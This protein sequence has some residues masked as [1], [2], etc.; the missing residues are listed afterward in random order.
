MGSCLCD[1]SWCVGMTVQGVRAG[2]AHLAY[3]LGERSLLAAGAE[4]G[5][6]ECRRQLN[7]RRR[8][9]FSTSAYS[10]YS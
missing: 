1:F 5:G 3:W 7:Q 6:V 10:V 9:S 4:R 8:G 2:P